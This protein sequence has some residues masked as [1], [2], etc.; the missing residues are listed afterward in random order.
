MEGKIAL[1]KA[2]APFVGGGIGSMTRVATSR[3]DGLHLRCEIDGGLNWEGK[4]QEGDGQAHEMKGSESQNG[5]ENAW[6]ERGDGFS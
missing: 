6:C 2:Q 5:P 1:I 4:K 3:E